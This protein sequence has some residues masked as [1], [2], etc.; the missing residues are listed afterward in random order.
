MKKATKFLALFLILGMLAMVFLACNG[1]APDTDAEPPVSEDP[2]DPET[3]ETPE[4]PENPENPEDPETPEDPA[5][6]SGGNT[7]NDNK[8]EIGDL[9]GGLK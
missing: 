5:P 9:I 1:N 7:G 8:V 6:P 4:D 3:P 2:T